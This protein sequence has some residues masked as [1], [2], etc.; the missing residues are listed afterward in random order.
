[1]NPKELS[2]KTVLILGA[3]KTGISAAQFLLDKA[4]KI[5]LS[6]AGNIDTI[7]EHEVSSL[8]KNGV[9][10]ETNK[11]SEGFLNQADL[12]IVSP[13]ISPFTKIIQAAQAKN[14]PTVSDIELASYFTNKPL[15]CIT[16]TNGKTTTTS[17]I[18]HILNKNNISTL[19]C[20]NI[21][22]PIFNAIK[23][24]KD[25]QYLVIEVSSYQIFYSPTLSAYISVCLN[26]TPDHLDWHKSF[27]H[28]ISSK[29]KLFDNQKKDSWAILNATDSILKNFHPK[30]NIFYFTT[31]ADNLENYDHIA[32]FEDSYLKIKYKN[33]IESIIHK[34]KL[35][36]FGMHNIENTLASIAV[37][38]ILDI[39]SVQDSLTSFQG[40]EH[41]LERTKSIG[42]KEFYN[43]SK[44]TNPE[45]TI[46]AIEAI[47]MKNNG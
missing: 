24:K 25:F 42:E 9:E 44:A 34:D 28:Y 22:T 27:D 33:N 26:I 29:K 14:I 3:G 18:T 47:R 43:D 13:G 32:F 6:D 11:N 8:K 15:I 19:C 30:N 40:V 21:G 20:G 2:T 36:I 41:R 12:I 5:L 23:S 31:T 7:Y 39:K 1:M 46:K 4:N 37:S 16:G 38:R 45:S 10:V 17:L 35:N